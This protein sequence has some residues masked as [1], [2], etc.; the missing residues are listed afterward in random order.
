MA[1]QKIGRVLSRSYKK[2]FGKKINPLPDK[3]TFLSDIPF[4]AITECLL[5][6]SIQRQVRIEILPNSLKKLAKTY[7]STK[8]LEKEK[9]ELIRKL[10]EAKYQMHKL[11]DDVSKL[12]SVNDQLR[13]NIDDNSI[14]PKAYF[15]SNMQIAEEKGVKL[16]GRPLQGGL[17]GLGKKR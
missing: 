8:R 12:N 17:P 2:D 3:F 10:K 6:D 15:K 4:Y 9:K 5:P 14:P 1:R 11:N 13:K 16:H 7:K